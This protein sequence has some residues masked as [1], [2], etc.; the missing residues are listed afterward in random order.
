MVVGVWTVAGRHLGLFLGRN[1]SSN[2]L[3]EIQWYLF[4]ADFLL[5]GA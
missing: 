4:A 2:R 5:G 3:I 1:L